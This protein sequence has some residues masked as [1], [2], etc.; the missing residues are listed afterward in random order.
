MYELH[1]KQAASRP[2]SRWEEEGCSIKTGGQVLLISG[3]FP[4]SA[5][6]TA[7]ASQS[8]RP[9]APPSISMT[10]STSEPATMSLSAIESSTFTRWPPQVNLH[11]AGC[12]SRAGS[13]EAGWG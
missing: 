1:Y 4:A 9:R 13:G 2:G 8:Y 3:P 12:G 10:H 7:A 5:A 11:D 6:A